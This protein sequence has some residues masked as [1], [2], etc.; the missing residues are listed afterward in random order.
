MLWHSLESQT[1]INSNIS[2]SDK[3]HHHS[4]L[5]CY[6]LSPAQAQ[7]IPVLEINQIVFEVIGIGKLRSRAGRDT[8]TSD[9]QLFRDGRLCGMVSDFTLFFGDVVYLSQ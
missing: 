1:S 6:L 4:L 3:F 8:D 7:L 5:F 9:M 2:S